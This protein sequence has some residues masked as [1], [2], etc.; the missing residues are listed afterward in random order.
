[1]HRE[2]S[3]SQS[4]VPR[5]SQRGL[6]A[7]S[8]LEDALTGQYRVL[9]SIGQGNFST[10]RLARHILTGTEVDIMKAVEHTNVVQL[11]QVMETADRVYLVMEYASG[12]QLLQHIPERVGLQEEEEPGLFRQMARALRTCHA[13]GIGHRDV[14]ADNILMDEQSHIKLCN[15]GLGCQ[16]RRGEL[17]DTV[18]GTPTYWAPEMFLLE[19][20]HPRGAE[21]AS[22]PWHLR[23]PSL[24]VRLVAEMLTMDLEERPRLAEV[25]R[26]PWLRWGQWP[27]VSCTR[28][29]LPIYPDLST[30]K[31]MLDLGFDLTDTWMSLKARKFDKAMATYLL[32]WHQYTQGAGFMVQRRSVHLGLQPRSSAG[33]LPATL[34]RQRSASK[35]TSHSRRVVPAV[36]QPPGEQLQPWQ[37]GSTGG[38]LPALALPSLQAQGPAA[39]GRAP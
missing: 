27:F 28:E 26:H 3:E 15:F 32:L 5:S 16:F 18:C 7:S 13:K 30:V 23:L 9:R 22:P 36:Q 12:G 34:P 10:L 33:S 29:C 24:S 2:S 6:E 20:D 14:K 11:F 21:V 4:S 17:L 37:R 39:P 19:E 25:L 1:M 8:S 38:S 35:P 31:A